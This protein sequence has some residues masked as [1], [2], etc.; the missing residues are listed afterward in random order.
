[1]SR[2]WYNIFMFEPKFF[3]TPEINNRIAKIEK[4][5][6]LVDQA[7]IL[8]ELEVQLRFRATVE[9]V[10][11]STSIEGNPLSKQQVKKVL[12]GNT[13]TAPDY[14]IKEVLNYK[15]ALDWL[16]KEQFK[17]FLSPKQIKFVHKILMT[18]LLP[19]NKVGT[20]RSGSVYIIDEVK[21]KEIIQYTGSDSNDLPKL[22]TSFIQWLS[23]QSKKKKYHPVLLAGLVHY[24][25]VSIHPFSDSNGRITRLLTHHYLNTVNYDFRQS[26]SL[27]AYYLQHRQE[28]YQAL[29]RGKTFDDRMDADITEFIDFFTKG[30]LQSVKNVSHYIQTGKVTEKGQKP[31]RLSQDELHILDFIYEF[32]SINV[33]EAIDILSTT[34]RTAQRRLSGLVESNTL[35]VLGK[36][37]ATKYLLE[38]KKN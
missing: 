34:K 29:S 6:T 11:S 33:R 25:F 38:S 28:Y 20:W 3:I 31:L 10:H 8:P 22:V 26:L 7:T 9:T 37:P 5:K 21:G 32:G 4:Y 12:H 13:I 19:K 2:L 15:K 14:A 35:K 1:M 23:V 30:F 18:D 27:D 24:I 17:E 36:G 16:D